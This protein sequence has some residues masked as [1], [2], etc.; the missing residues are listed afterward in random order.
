MCLSEL[1]FR[2]CSLRKT[3]LLA[4]LASALLVLAILHSWP[5]RAYTT[6]DRWQPQGLEVEKHLLERLPEADHQMG[7]ISLHVRDYVARYGRFWNGPSTAKPALTSSRVHLRSLLA[8]NGCVCEGESGGVNLPVA[9][10]LFP[11][12]STMLLHTAFNASELEDVKQR[13]AKEYRSF[14]KR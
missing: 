6:V 13:R 3:L 5:T 4:I 1:V 2:M 9:R 14:Q 11:G 8:R 12:V 7:N 10:L